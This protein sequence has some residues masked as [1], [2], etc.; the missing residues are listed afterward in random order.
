MK[1]NVSQEKENP[2]LNRR[3]LKGKI[4]HLGEATPS[5]EQVEEFLSQK[6]KVDKKNVDVNKIF[7]QKGKQ[8]SIFLANIKGLKKKAK[9]KKPKKKTKKKK[10]KPK[11]KKVDY[12]KILSGTISE[13]KKK[14]KK[15]KKPD[16]KKLLE[17]EKKNKDRKGMK[18]FLK[19]QIEKG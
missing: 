14:I 15:L 9:K 3:E 5:R 12:E 19:K 13:G 6:L 11:K 17:I 7:T 2:F 4:G 10:T 8:E 18:K 16:Y 1:V